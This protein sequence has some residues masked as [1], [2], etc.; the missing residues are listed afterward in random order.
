MQYFFSPKSNKENKYNSYLIGT[1]AGFPTSLES[2]GGKKEKHICMSVP[3]PWSFAKPFKG[4]NIF[5][6]N[7]I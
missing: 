2:Y 6:M 7:A 1:W 5:I 3:T 4:N